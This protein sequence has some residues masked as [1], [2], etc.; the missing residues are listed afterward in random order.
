MVTNS[1]RANRGWAQNCSHHHE[2][3]SVRGLFLNFSSG[4]REETETYK[5]ED[6]R[7]FII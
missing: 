5:K 6:S 2:K 3:R 7:L 4:Q 1:T